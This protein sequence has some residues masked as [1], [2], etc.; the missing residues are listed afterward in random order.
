MKSWM[1]RLFG[2]I[3]VF[4][5]VV[6]AIPAIAE[7]NSIKGRIV[8]PDGKLA[9][10]HFPV[11]IQSP[12]GT[13]V[14]MTD[15]Y[16]EFKIESLMPGRYEIMPANEPALTEVVLIPERSIWSKLMKSKGE[17]EAVDIGE[18]HIEAGKMY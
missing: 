5:I 17:S 2:I 14:T 1:V 6:F 16:G 9:I 15:D 12:E 13:L 11:L 7:E 18:F 4:T 3:G 10:K 8:T